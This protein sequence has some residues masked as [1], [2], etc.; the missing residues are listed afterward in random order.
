[1]IQIFKC[2]TEERKEYQPIPFWSWNDRLDKD[3]L[4]QQI[5]WMKACGIGGFF[6]HA[7]SGLKT[8]YLSQEWMEC[9]EACCDEARAL[10]MQA[11]A[12]DEN[13]WPSGFVGGKLLENPENHDMYI[14]HQIGEFDES[15]DIQYLLTKDSIIRTSKAEE[16][17]AQTASVYRNLY[18]GNDLLGCG[19]SAQGRSSNHQNQKHA[20]QHAEIITLH[21]SHLHLLYPIV[22]QIGGEFNMVS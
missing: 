1:M 11:W 2:L 21:P 13:G 7:R 3:K 17:P 15:A 6:M 4:I 8:T 5:R 18:D 19:G 12:Y 14:E 16:G 22:T 9:I 10:G 20:E